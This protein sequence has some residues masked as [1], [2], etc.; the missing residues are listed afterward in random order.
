MNYIIYDNVQINLDNVLYIEK[1]SRNATSIQGGSVTWYEVRLIFNDDVRV[2][3]FDKESVRDS[4]ITS[5]NT[6]TN[7]TE[8]RVEDK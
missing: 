7:P 1:Y 3:K 4:F 5:L 2:F 8:I 6:V